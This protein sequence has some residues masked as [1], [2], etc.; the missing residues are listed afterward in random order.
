[1]FGLLM[2][3]RALL[4]LLKLFAGST[5][6]PAADAF[7]GSAFLRAKSAASLCNYDFSISF[8]PACSR[9]DAEVQDHARSG[10]QT[11]QPDLN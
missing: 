10:R 7:Q 5:F 6:L 2:L 11:R 3:F 1:M 8:P 4:M 9:A